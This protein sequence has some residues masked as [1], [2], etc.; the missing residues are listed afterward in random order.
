MTPVP[1][2]AKGCVFCDIVSGKAAA[3]RRQVQEKVRRA[4][5]EVRASPQ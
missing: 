1:H 2:S 5:E 4:V 3:A